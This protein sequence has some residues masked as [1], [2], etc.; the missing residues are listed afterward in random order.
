MLAPITTWAETEVNTCGQVFSDNAFLSSDLDCSAF[1]GDAV[2]LDGGKL[3]LRGFTLTGGS[4]GAVVAVRCSRSCRVVSDPPGGMVESAAIAAISGPAFGARVGITV[5]GLVIDGGG[6]ATGVQ[7]GKRVKIVDSTI[8]NVDRGVALSDSVRVDNSTITNAIDYGVIASKVR[9]KDSQLINAGHALMTSGVSGRVVVID[10]TVSGGTGVGVSG[11][12]VRVTN[13]AITGNA[14][15][16]IEAFAARSIRVKD[17]DISGNGGKGIFD[18]TDGPRKVVVQNTTITGNGEEG[19]NVPVPLLIKSGSV[20]TDN[21]LDGVNMSH[22]LEKVKVVVKD[23]TLTGN[24][25]HL[26]CGVVQTCADISTTQAPIVTNTTCNTS[27]DITSGFPGTSW[28]LCA[29]D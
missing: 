6:V 23:S 5:E 8:S 21:G 20:I 15:S 18:P 2:T 26:D 7:V 14:G 11:E 16:G 19:I 28:D 24:G 13:G 29:L 17:S 9:V 1:A 27:Y 12:R 22:P 3:D 25:T 4:A 10:S